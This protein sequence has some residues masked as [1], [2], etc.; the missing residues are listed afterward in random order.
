MQLSR[1]RVGAWIETAQ[2]YRI[3]AGLE[4]RPRVGAWIETNHSY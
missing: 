1:P 3:Y 2:I 4:R